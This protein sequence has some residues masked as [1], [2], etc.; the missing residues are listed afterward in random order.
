MFIGLCAYI[1]AMNGIFGFE[2]EEVK[3]WRELYNEMLHNFRTLPNTV[4]IK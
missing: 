2:K 3:E 1:W 4:T